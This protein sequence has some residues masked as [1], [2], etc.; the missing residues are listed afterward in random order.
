MAKWRI[1][2]C[3]VLKESVCGCCICRHQPSCYIR[4]RRRTRHNR[5]VWTRLWILDHERQGAFDHLMQEIRMCN[6]S[7][8]RNVVTMNAAMFEELHCLVHTRRL[9]RLLRCLRSTMAM[10]MA[11]A[12][13]TRIL[14]ESVW[15]RRNRRVWTRQWILDHERQGAFNHNMHSALVIHMC[16]SCVL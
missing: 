15:R 14:K 13:A 12:T 2:I 5:R 4:R 9:R 6:T 3:V 11:D 8:Y 16:A 7:S 1:S 10:M